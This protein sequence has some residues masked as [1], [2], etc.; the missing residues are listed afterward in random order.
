[1]IS[2]KRRYRKYREKNKNYLIIF[3][4]VVCIILCITFLKFGLEYE[5]K[6]E[7]I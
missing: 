7:Y 1:M 6:S 3:G 2:R 4:I 5:E